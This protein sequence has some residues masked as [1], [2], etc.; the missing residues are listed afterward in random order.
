MTLRAGDALDF[1][2]SGADED[3]EPSAG[4]AAA[5]ADAK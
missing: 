2:L 4:A 5:S 1:E 3:E